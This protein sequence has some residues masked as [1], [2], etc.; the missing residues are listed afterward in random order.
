MTNIKK[1]EQNLNKYT[2]CGSVVKRRKDKAEVRHVSR[3]EEMG[4]NMA[5]T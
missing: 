2:S 4:V 1:L 5:I 3:V